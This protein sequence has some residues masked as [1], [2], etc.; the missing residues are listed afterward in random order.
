M[1]SLRTW[2]DRQLSNPQIVTLGLI[3]LVLALTVYFFGNM[4][5][6]LFAA[7]VIAY[8]LEGI[9][10][11]LERRG[12]PHLGAVLIVFLSFFAFLLF[13]AFGLLPMLVRQLTSFAQQVPTMIAKV[14]AVLMD[15]PQR[16]SMITERQIEE[17]L[18]GINSEILGVGQTLLSYSL[19]SLITAITVGVYLVLVPILVFFLLKDRD[20]I[21]GWV[22]DFLPTDRI[23]ADQVWAEVD[24]Q[25]G[26]Y[27]RGKTWEIFI[28]GSVTFS[29]FTFLGLQYSLLL[30]V[31]TGFSVL[32]P[33]IGAFIVTL[34][35]AGVAIFQFGLQPEFYWVLI[36]YGIIQFL[37]GNLLVPL[38]FSEAVSLHPVAI[39][40]AILLFGGL[41]GFWGVFF[42]IPLATVIQAVLRAWPRDLKSSSDDPSEVIGVG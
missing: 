35:V 38:L 8:L 7:V 14:Q 12:A 41:W 26:N 31:I 37:D 21:I 39:I 23:L 6:P 33:Y 27:A 30:A 36:A 24:G 25:I 1:S 10:S 42:A 2:F 16:F 22:S 9:V 29:V 18:S 15:L 11:R 17:L 20:D 13:A 4:L 40:A 28:V 32:V 19:S 34:P 3:I 5:A